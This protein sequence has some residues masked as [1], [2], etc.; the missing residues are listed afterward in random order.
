MTAGAKVERSKYC[1]RTH[2]RHAYRLAWAGGGGGERGGGERG[3]GLLF[4]SHSPSPFCACHPDY[5]PKK[6]V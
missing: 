2:S 4:F 1:T 3:G 6:N 5:L